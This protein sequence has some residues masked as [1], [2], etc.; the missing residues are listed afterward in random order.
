ML[1]SSYTTQDNVEI[2]EQQFEVW[3]NMRGAPSRSHKY[4]QVELSPELRLRDPYHRPQLTILLEFFY[5][6]CRFC[7]CIAFP[8][9]YL[10]LW[11]FSTCA[12]LN[13][14][15]FPL[16]FFT[17]ALSGGARKSWHHFWFMGKKSAI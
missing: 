13:H 7:G 14:R 16:R 10:P 8:L 6:Y 9:L 17:A 12:P 11:S 4:F 5:F 1:P 15:K 3:N 2:A